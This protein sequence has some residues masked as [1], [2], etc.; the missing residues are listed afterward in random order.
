ML[1]L[2]NLAGEG[3]LGAAIFQTSLAKIDTSAEGDRILSIEE[4]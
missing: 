1:D 3:D 4:Q 2:V